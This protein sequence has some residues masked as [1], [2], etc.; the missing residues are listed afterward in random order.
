MWSVRGSCRGSGTYCLLLYIDAD[1]VLH[2]QGPQYLGEH[3]SHEEGEVQIIACSAL[4]NTLFV[5]CWTYGCTASCCTVTE[6][7]IRTLNV[8]LPAWGSDF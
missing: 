2:V 5:R 4:L 3:D 7:L 6:T 1:L 8:C